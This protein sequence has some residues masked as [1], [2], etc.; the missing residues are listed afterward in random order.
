MSDYHSI[1]SGLQGLGQ[2]LWQKRHE[3]QMPHL[4]QLDAQ[5]VASR[6]V[7]SLCPYHHARWQPCDRFPDHPAP[8]RKLVSLQHF[9]R[10]W[11]GSHFG[12]GLRWNI[13]KHPWTWEF[14]WGWSLHC[15]RTSDVRYWLSRCHGE[16]ESLHVTCSSTD[17]NLCSSRHCVVWVDFRFDR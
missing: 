4:S 3:K 17:E 16:L 15:R 7:N 10:A 5:S 13:W 9:L 12:W 1:S 8:W 11:L 14:R 6:L 2:I